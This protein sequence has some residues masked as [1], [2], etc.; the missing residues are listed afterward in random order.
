M[1]MSVIS[2]PFPTGTI[3]LKILPKIETKG[4]TADDVTLLSEQSFGIMRSAFL[5][6]SGQSVQS[7]GPSTHWS[8]RCCRALSFAP[9][10][11]MAWVYVV[12]VVVVT[13]TMTTRRFS[14]LSDVLMKQEHMSIQTDRHTY[15]HL[16]YSTYSRCY[17]SLVSISRWTPGGAKRRRFPA[18]RCLGLLSSATGWVLERRPENI[19]DVRSTCMPFLCFS[20]FH[21]S[22]KTQVLFVCV[23]RFFSRFSACVVGNRWQTS[24]FVLLRMQEYF[25]P[26]LIYRPKRLIWKC[27]VYSRGKLFVSSQPRIRKTALFL[28]PFFVVKKLVRNKHLHCHRSS[29]AS[30]CAMCPKCLSRWLHI[31]VKYC[32][33]T[34]LIIDLWSGLFD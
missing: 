3:T 33:K 22:T 15:I 19:V 17:L 34:L 18:W 29:A 32:G 10:T 13:V 16:D 21:W 27:P 6:I 14:I 30:S 25:S 7:N 4:L 2:A 24:V 8:P 31:R 20:S 23:G 11:R 5:E 1:I 12:V 9:T 26:L 28:F